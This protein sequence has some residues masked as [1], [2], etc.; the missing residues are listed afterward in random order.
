MT[1]VTIAN[2]A[3]CAY[4]EHQHTEECASETVLICEINVPD[5]SEET[6]ETERTEETKT[7]E[8]SAETEKAEQ[9]HTH[10]EACYGT[11]YSCG[12]EAH[13]HQI[14]C[15][16]DPTA[17]AETAE[18]WEA[19]LPELTGRAGEDVLLIA[20]SQLG[21]KESEKNYVLAEDGETKAG[22]T[23]YGQWYG[24]PYLLL[25]A[26][27]R[28]SRVPRPFR[29]R[30]YAEKLGRGQ[31]ILQCRQLSAYGRRCGLPG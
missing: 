1:G 7:A 18:I 5:Q 19:T 6:A 10:T 3:S 14:S 13:I 28:Y 30:G 31:A 9:G 27:C 15:F 4:E 26:L 20:R 21:Y 16:S 2:G 11:V 24:N 25:P 22:I 17:D 8:E 29:H 23:R 12:K